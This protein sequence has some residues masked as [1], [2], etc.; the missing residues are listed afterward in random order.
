MHLPIVWCRAPHGTWFLGVS[1]KCYRYK[2]Q[3]VLGASDGERWRATS[4]KTEPWDVVSHV[5]GWNRW[6]SAAILVFSLR[7]C[8]VNG[9]NAYCCRG[10]GPAELLQVQT[11]PAK[12]LLLAQR[13]EEFSPQC[14]L[15]LNVYAR[16][17]IGWQGEYMR[18]VPSL[19]AGKWSCVLKQDLPQK[20][21]EMR[22]GNCIRK[23]P[24]FSE[25][26]QFGNKSW[27]VCCDRVAVWETWCLQGRLI[28]CGNCLA[29]GYFSLHGNVFGH[30]TH[31]LSVPGTWCL[32]LVGRNPSSSVGEVGRS[33]QS[34]SPCQW[35]Q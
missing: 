13:A 16:G 27:R 19:D 5:L 29:D 9:T 18:A 12:R 21:S 6:A 14:D 22:K 23:L 8:R 24:L 4:L 17:R 31:R 10:V 26:K 32:L 15:S 35:H 2:Q 30:W 7:C 11:N 20:L 3:H 1:L 34:R 28:F 25:L 33:L